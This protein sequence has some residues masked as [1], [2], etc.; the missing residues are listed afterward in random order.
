M[1]GRGRGA[2]GGGAG[3]GREVEGR[4]EAPA[5]EA[6]TQALSA[7]DAALLATPQG[8]GEAISEARASI[9]TSQLYGR[10][11]KWAWIDD[12]WRSRDW[13]VSRE[14]F[15]QRLVQSFRQT[16]TFTARRFDLVTA[17]NP[18]EFAKYSAS[19]IVTSPLSRQEVHLI[20]VQ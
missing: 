10:D 3:G 17:L 7:R 12:V 2:G 14:V 1:G 5:A 9:P 13:G 15:N 4:I 11:V 19:S 18:T 8:L 16:E 20:K 6:V